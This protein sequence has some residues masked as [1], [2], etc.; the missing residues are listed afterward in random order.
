MRRLAV[1]TIALAALS[2]ASTAAARVLLVGTYHRRIRI[3]TRN[4]AP[5]SS[6]D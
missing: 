4:H 3:L 2:L 5:A 6:G 1:V